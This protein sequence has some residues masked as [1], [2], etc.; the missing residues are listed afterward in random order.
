M[1]PLDRLHIEVEG[2]GPGVC[3]DGGIATIGEGAGLPVAESSDVVLVTA[4][5][6]LFGSP[7]IPLLAGK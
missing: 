4:E 3:T 1:G 5:G 2:A 7:L 6:L